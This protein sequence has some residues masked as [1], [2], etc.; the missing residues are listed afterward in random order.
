MPEPTSKPKRRIRLHYFLLGF[1]IVFCL[2]ADFIAR[3][4]LLHP[5]KLDAHWR[6]LFPDCEEAFFKTADGSL[7]HGLYFPYV[8]PDSGTS[9][10]SILYSHG[11]GGTV[12]DWGNEGEMLR[13]ELRVSVFVYDYRGYGKS[14]GKPTARGILEDGRAARKWLA[15]RE[16]IAEPEIIV[17]GRS[18]GGA[19]A[20]DLATGEGAKALIVESTFT[21]LPD[22]SAKM[23]PFFPARWFLREQ[24]P[25][26]ERIAKYDGPLFLSHG[27]ADTL[28]PFEQGRR[29]FE[30]AAGRS[31]MFVPI[32]D[33]GHNTP[34]PD[35][36]YAKL[37]CFVDTLTKQ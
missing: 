15:E 24:L 25:S 12:A 26:I 3:K 28:I 22:M 37:R 36:Y 8:D 17:M 35:G 6:P 11:N 4:M 34:P 21:S 5:T 23:I 9:R 18:L 2:Q 1:L 19:V 30:A 14:E 29:L 10:G 33:G 32:P 31:K 20:I 27:T 16:K 7:L 13:D